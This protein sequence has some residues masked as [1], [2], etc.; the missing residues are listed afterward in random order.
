MK[1]TNTR[2]EERFREFVDKV[3]LAKTDIDIA[4]VGF[5]L[6]EA[7]MGFRTRKLARQSLTIIDSV[8]GEK[9]FNSEN[10]KE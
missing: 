10:R 7:Y 3:K 5:D 1:N 2:A 4:L 8:F 9:N 6:V